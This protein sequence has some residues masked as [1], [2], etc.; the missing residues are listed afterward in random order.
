MP[1]DRAAVPIAP[2]GVRLKV[3]GCRAEVDGGL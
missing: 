2:F 1:I 3:A